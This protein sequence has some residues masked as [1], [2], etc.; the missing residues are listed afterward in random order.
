M[1]KKTKKPNKEHIKETMSS[2]NM[3]EEEAIKALENAANAPYLNDDG[4]MPIAIINGRYI[5]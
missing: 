3:T 5:Y 4:R 2:L 1:S